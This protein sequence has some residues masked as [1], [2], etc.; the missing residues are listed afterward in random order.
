MDFQVKPLLGNQIPVF[1]KRLQAGGFGPWLPEVGAEIGV[2]VFCVVAQERLDLEIHGGW[3]R[4]EPQK[5]FRLDFKGMHS[6]DLDWAVF[7]QK[8]EQ[9]QFNNLNLRNGGQHVWG[10]KIQDAVLGDL[11]SETHLVST[12]WRP[13]ELYL[14]S[15]YWGMYAA[16]DKSDEHFIAAEFG[17]SPDDVTLLNPQGALAGNAAPFNAVTSA[18]LA[19]PPNASE[20]RSQF[21]SAF[22]VMNYFDYFTV[23]TFCQNMDWM[24]IAWG[25][26]NTKVCKPSSNHK[27]HY[28]L[29]DTDACLGYWGTSPWENY[30]EYARN[31]GWPSPH[32][33]LFNH[34]LNNPA[35]AG[36]SSTGMQTW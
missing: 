15:E 5:S 24:G 13:L 31:P 9:H 10:T 8:P 22:N 3:S 17:V 12:A 16:R 6:G 23:E 30:V 7:P 4:A 34:V 29:Y 20:F 36:C 27:W 18:L 26:N 14:N 21:E 25:L 11:A 19:L 32:S 35:C 2:V 33:E 1:I 28:I